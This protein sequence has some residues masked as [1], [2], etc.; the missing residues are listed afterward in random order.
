MH[1]PIH[2]DGEKGEGQGEKEKEANV[3]SKN[4]SSGPTLAGIH[5]LCIL[6]ISRKSPELWVLNL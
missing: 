6:Q 5:V 1:I 2:R 3:E 4:P